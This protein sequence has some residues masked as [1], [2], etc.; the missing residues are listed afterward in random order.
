[1]QQMNMNNLCHN[2]NILAQRYKIITIYDNSIKTNP[3][4]H[5]I[6]L[7]GKQ[8]NKQKNHPIALNRRLPAHPLCT[9]PRMVFVRPIQNKKKR[10]NPSPQLPM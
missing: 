3:S 6:L 9:T 1:M 10:E 5:R 7:C 8:N 4:E 2:R